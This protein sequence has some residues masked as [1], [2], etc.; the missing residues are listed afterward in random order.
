MVAILSKQREAILGAV[1]AMYTDVASHPEKA[2]HFPTG[3]DACLFVGYPEEILE[4]IPPSALES[5][6]GVGFPFAAGAVR[7]GDV[8][9]DIGSGAGTDVLITSRLVGAEGKVFGLDMTEAM[10]RKLE[11]NAA[12]MGARNVEPVE[13]NAEKIPLPDESVD[14]VTSNGVLNL[15]PDKPRAVRE[16]FRVLR[17]GGRVQI[18]DIVLRRPASEA[19]RT[20]PELWAECIV[21]ATM[22]DTYLGMFRSAAFT[23]VEV[24][25]THDYF[26]GSASPET[27]K[28]AASLGGHAI[29][30]HAVKPL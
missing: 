1:Q 26:S 30:M 12:A 17:P 24:L 18:A 10:L 6:A 29:V 13:G 15:V 27:R 14:V 21:G 7:S 9:L 19:C 4:G 16:I 23:A 11:H 3:R 2:F 25:E 5:F 8:A 20:H 22:E 28:L